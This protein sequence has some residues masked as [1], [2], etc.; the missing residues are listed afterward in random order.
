MALGRARA[1]C[2]CRASSHR[3]AAPT[4]QQMS[5]DSTFASCLRT[6]AR[7]SQQLR[8]EV[9]RISDINEVYDFSTDNTRGYGSRAKLVVLRD[10]LI[11][12]RRPTLAST[13]AYTTTQYTAM[14]QPRIPGA[15]QIA[16]STRPKTRWGGGEASSDSACHV[17]KRTTSCAA[18]P[19]S[20]R[21]ESPTM[22]TPST[23]QA[24]LYNRRSCE[25][26]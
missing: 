7:G 26:R 22:K 12:N 10:M 21:N 25:Q 14:Y 4:A 23:N 2:S 18:K 8:R 15:R 11:L 24:Q 6:G 1:L 3:P 5:V 17:S 16:Q 9:D 20:R 13:P 19:E